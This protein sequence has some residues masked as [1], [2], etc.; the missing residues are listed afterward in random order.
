MQAVRITPTMS[1][2]AG[3]YS[4]FECAIPCRYLVLNTMYAIDAGDVRTNMG[5]SR[6]YPYSRGW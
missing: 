4:R 6:K 1:L 3:K 5:T 2:K